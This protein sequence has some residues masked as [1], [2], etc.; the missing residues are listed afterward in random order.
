MDLRYREI[1]MKHQEDH[2]NRNWR[3]QRWG[4][5]KLPCIFI[6]PAS[7]YFPSI[8]K[9]LQSSLSLYGIDYYWTT[10]ESRPSTAAINQSTILQWIQDVDRLR[11][12]LK[13]EKVIVWGPSA[14][15]YLALCY[16][17][18]YPE[19][20]LGVIMLGSPLTMQNLPAESQRFFK[21]Q[22]DPHAE[23]YSPR[24]KTAASQEKW[25][26]FQRLN[27]QYESTHFK[28]GLSAYLHELVRDEDKYYLNKEK[29]K[30]M[31]LRWSILNI[32]ARNRFFSIIF[33]FDRQL[34]Q[35]N[36]A[37]FRAVQAPVLSVLGIADAIVPCYLVTDN[38]HLWPSDFEYHI[39]SGSAHLSQLENPD[40]F[41]QV[42]SQWLQT[43]IEK[44]YWQNLQL[45]QESSAKLRSLL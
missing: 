20:T 26:R 6:G 11:Q 7:I 39:D 5:G 1:I 36:P 45:Q 43:K 14:L 2:P 8:P 16:A 30:T 12:Q 28:N 22:Y 33:A 9:S 18:Y 23:N 29:A 19:H 17:L 35:K 25:D 13:L 37:P 40:Q 44:V 41:S 3:I 38:W 32:T 27:Q 31:L 21:A 34:H 10:T 15:G 4:Q 24:L 42:V